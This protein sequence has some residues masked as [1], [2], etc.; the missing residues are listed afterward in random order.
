MSTVF[1]PSIRG[2]VGDWV[3]YTSVMPIK[4]LADRVDFVRDVH[5]SKTLSEYLQRGIDPKRTKK[6][7]DYLAKTDER[8][9][10]SLVLAVYKNQPEWYPAAVE[11]SEVEANSIQGDVGLLKF[12]GEEMIIPID[13]QH[14]LAGIKKLLERYE[15]DE[16]EENDSFP[17]MKDVIPVIFI[18]HREKSEKTMLRTRRLFTTLNKYAVKVNRF[19]IISL[20]EDDP[21]A[22]TTR[23][24]V[25][26]DERFG[27]GRIKFKGGS[28]INLDDGCL[29][30]VENLYD[31]LTIL[32]TRI[33]Q[34]VRPSTLTTGPRPS[35]A[36]LL[37]YRKSA[38]EFF[39]CIEGSYSQIASYFNADNFEE[40]AQKERKE[41]HVLFRPIGLKLFANLIAKYDDLSIEERFDRIKKVPVYMKAPPY[42][43]LLI[44]EQGKMHDGN[45]TKVRN[46]LLSALGFD[47]SPTEKR[48]ARTGLSIMWNEPLNRVRNDMIP[49]DFDEMIKL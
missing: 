9:F 20:D 16:I 6:I 4:E 28:N 38:L 21:M 32:F 36:D 30:S 24:L 48:S 12:D 10:N 34:K 33:I 25:E 47:L 8:F 22:I 3:Y 15:D 5:K 46:L 40:Y 14:R 42:H 37:W 49:T 23:W 35:K 43:G 26:H 7:S 31:V 13:G 1:F 29:T 18:A 19:E 44:S 2:T 41:G 27:E 17:F 11:S 45:E 39:D